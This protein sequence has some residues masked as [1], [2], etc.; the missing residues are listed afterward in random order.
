MKQAIE[1][2]Q[3]VKF[4]GTGPALAA[5]TFRLGPVVVR[6]SRL[7]ETN[8]K[9]WLSLPSR[10][11]TEGNWFHI[12]SLNNRELKTQLDEM[13]S[14]AYDRVLQEEDAPEFIPAF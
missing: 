12:I 1:I 7:M 14:R 5:V 13:A 2:R 11:A 9:R 6:G 10:R 8:G 4:S 3:V